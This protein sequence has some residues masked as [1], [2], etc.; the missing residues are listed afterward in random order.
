MDLARL[1]LTTGAH[2]ALIVIPDSLKVYKF[3]TTGDYNTFL[4]MHATSI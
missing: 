3:A 4:Q 1:L 2:S